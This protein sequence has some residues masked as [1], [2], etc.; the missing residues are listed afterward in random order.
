MRP[1]EASPFWSVSRGQDG[2]S[3]W[4]AETSL[5]ATRQNEQFSGQPNAL[6]MCV[7]LIS[8]D[9][10]IGRHSTL[11]VIVIDVPASAN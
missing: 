6:P 2:R 5:A 9:M 7:A 3:L 8:A 4:R 10:G 1:I 11:S